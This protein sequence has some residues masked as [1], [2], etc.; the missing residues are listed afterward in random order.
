M[1]DLRN[2]AIVGLY[3]ADQEIKAAAP[4]FKAFIPE[5]D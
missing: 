4:R 1:S 5:K 2:S 3:L